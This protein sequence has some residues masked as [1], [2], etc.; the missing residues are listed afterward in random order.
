MVS[1]EFVRILVY[2]FMR[3]FWH[4]HRALAILSY[5]VLA[6]LLLAITL[7]SVCEVT[8]KYSSATWRPDEAS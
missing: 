4:R 3:K 7:I 1:L 2:V 6:F 8:R 5:I